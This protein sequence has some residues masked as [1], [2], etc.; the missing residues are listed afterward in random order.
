[1][2]SHGCVR[3]LR[4]MYVQITKKWSGRKQISC[5]KL[6][7]YLWRIDLVSIDFGKF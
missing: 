5:I 3:M 6:M 7:H 1:M 2:M 4:K